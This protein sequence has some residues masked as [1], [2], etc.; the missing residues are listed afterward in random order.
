MRNTNKAVS[1]N[2]YDIASILNVTNISACRNGGN[3]YVKIDAT[4]KEPFVGWTTILN[5]LPL[6][7]TPT[8]IQ[9]PNAKIR[10]QDGALALSGVEKNAAIDT[11]ISYPAK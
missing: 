1:L 6:S 11:I 3:V 7:F 10:I 9:T 8:Y 4:A 2:I 5:G